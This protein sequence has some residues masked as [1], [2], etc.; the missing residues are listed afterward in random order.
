M[1]NPFATKVRPERPAAPPSAKSVNYLIDLAADK[2][3]A[4]N[5][6]VATTRTLVTT[7]AAE[8]SQREVSDEI[9][10]L[11]ALGFTG[12]VHKEAAPLGGEIEDG[13]Y[14]TADTIW[15]VYHTV[16]GRNEQVAKELVI[17][18][19][20]GE[21]VYRGKAPL[22]KIIATG[23]RLSLEE[24]RHFGSVYGQCCRCLVPLT[25]EI[26]I[27]LGIGPKCGEHEYAEQFKPLYDAA[28]AKLLATAS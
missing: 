23:R 18:G 27:A 7:W 21:F 28:K 2:A 6:D 1:P 12:R 15:K 5:K 22:S 9:D 24:A 19:D 4:E 26:S 3:F 13:M 8:H 25:H 11:K 20:K 17:T 16:H 14:V 10:R